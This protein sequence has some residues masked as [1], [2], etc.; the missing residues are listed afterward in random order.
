MR[1]RPFISSVAVALVTTLLALPSTVEA[2]EPAVYQVVISVDPSTGA[3]SYSQDPVIAYPGDRVVFSAPGVSTWTVTFH[4]ETPFSNR[5][6]S[7]TGEQ[8]RNVPILPTAATGSY[9]YDV[10][11]TVGDRTF[12]EDPEIIVRA[13]DEGASP[14]SSPGM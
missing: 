13:R 1:A 12:V 8:S 2:Q 14:P 9:A 10:S 11:V 7:G 6:I 3:L 4:G 5:E